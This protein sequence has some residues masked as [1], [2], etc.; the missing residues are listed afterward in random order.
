MSIIAS[1]HW[2][3]IF[4]DIPHNWDV[5]VKDTRHLILETDL[6]PVL[7]IR[8]QSGASGNAARN[9][10]K[11]AARL[12]RDGEAPRSEHTDPIS[13]ALQK[14]FHPKRFDPIQAV[15]D[16]VLLLTCTSCSTAIL[17][18]LYDASRE[19]LSAHP[20]VLDSLRCHANAHERQ[21]WRIQD[22]YFHIPD[23]FELKSASFRLGLNTL[24]FTARRTELTFFRMA[25]AAQHIQGSSLAQLFAS[26]CS[27]PS[28]DQVEKGLSTL[29][30]HYI[31]G[32]VE[33]IWSALRRKRVYRLASL[34]HFPDA[35]RI[36]GYSISS[37]CPIEN[38]LNSAIENGYGIIQEKKGVEPDQGPGTE[39]H[40][41]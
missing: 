23:G 29:H 34:S 41:G 38:E 9:F 25:A 10:E 24:F 22:F 18:K 27:A 28:V 12:S 31:P 7:E 16:S 15:S 40:A 14:S 39:L 3:G 1:I 33:K 32:P 5:I 11:I 8:W 19:K 30:Y 36:L 2:N 21:Q 37:R 20:F 4:L 17:V 13:T 35:D 6:K 26:L